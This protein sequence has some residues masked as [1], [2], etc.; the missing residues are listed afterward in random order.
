MSNAAQFWDRQASRYDT[1]EKH[2][3][4]TYKRIVENTR[5][6]LNAGSTVLDYGCGTGT[7]TVEIAPEVNVVRAL[8]LSSGMIDVAKSKAVERGIKNITF[9]RGTLFEQQESFDVI[10]AFNILH[11]LQHT[12]QVMQKIH[13]LLKPG[14]LFI[15]A[16]GCLAEKRSLVSF[17]MPLLSKTGIVPYVR[18]FKAAELKASIVEGGFHII[19][20]EILVQEPPSYFIVAEKA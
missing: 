19:E 16:T 1:T 11:L 15:S 14:G 9:A 12:S 8:D 4:P 10:L 5:R 7:I 2:Y 20:T 3:E 18:S 13:T 17:L 6:Y